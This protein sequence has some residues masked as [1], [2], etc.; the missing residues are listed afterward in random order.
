MKIS[1]PYLK[2]CGCCLE[3]DFKENL[4]SGKL[5]KLQTVNFKNKQK[6][7]ILIYEEIEKC[8]HLFHEIC[9]AKKLPCLICKSN[10]QIYYPQLTPSNLKKLSNTESYEEI[11]LSNINYL[12]KTEKYL[13]HKGFLTLIE[14]LEKV[15]KALF[16]LLNQ[17]NDAKKKL[18][19]LQLALHSKNCFFK[20]PQKEK[21]VDEK[22]KRNPFI[23]EK[24]L[25]NEKALYN[26]Y[27]RNYYHY[28][29]I[30][31]IIHDLVVNHI[32]GFH[33]RKAPF[34]LEHMLKIE[35][36]LKETDRN[37]D[38]LELI[39]KYVKKVLDFFNFSIIKKSLC[40][41]I[42]NPISL[43]KLIDFETK[44]KLPYIPIPENI[45]KNSVFSNFSFSKLTSYKVGPATYHR[46]NLDI[47]NYKIFEEFTDP[48]S[49]L[50]SIPIILDTLST[51]QNRDPLDHF[52][53]IQFDENSSLDNI[54]MLCLQ[55][56]ASSALSTAFNNAKDKNIYLNNKKNENR[57]N[58]K[59]KDGDILT[60]GGQKW[61]LKHKNIDTLSILLQKSSNNAYDYSLKTLL[62]L[63]IKNSPE[64]SNLSIY[65]LLEKKSVYLNNEIILRT[66]SQDNKIKALQN[67]AKNQKPP[68]T[69]LLALGKWKNG[70]ILQ[71]GNKKWFLYGEKEK[72]K[73]ISNFWKQ[74]Q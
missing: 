17:K 59:F 69:I 66:S 49:K 24:L 1:N 74:N 35:N 2:I 30:L 52:N 19:L 45:S 60:V 53:E 50:D 56:I 37:N 11:K 39:S 23:L 33:K 10:N 72:P 38:Q 9:V 25:E 65:E 14:T 8:K 73:K 22:Y 63:F 47:F 48:N 31:L 16:F 61:F 40:E 70:D 32:L 41:K 46:Q 4:Y 68:S 64:F 58:V 6:N 44:T 55:T 57:K 7:L 43:S 62:K 15:Q 34:L 12:I 67:I 51:V 36:I 5:R 42:K 20:K 27:L 18:E 71:I 3:E 13:S 26:G 54:L 28:T 29:S 21:K